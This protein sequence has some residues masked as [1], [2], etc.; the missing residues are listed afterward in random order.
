M[1]N[2]VWCS[3]LCKWYSKDNACLKDKTLVKNHVSLISVVTSWLTG[4]MYEFITWLITFKDLQ[5]ITLAAISCTF[6][7]RETLAFYTEPPSVS[8]HPLCLHARASALQNTLLS[9]IKI[10][11]NYRGGFTD[12]G[13]W[14]YA[15]GFGISCYSYAFAFTYTTS[16]ASSNLEINYNLNYPF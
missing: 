4:F 12:W 11:V 10:T 3:F 7:F 1:L 13:C 2:S 5:L 15:G 6:I 8:M 9:N 16:Q 14:N